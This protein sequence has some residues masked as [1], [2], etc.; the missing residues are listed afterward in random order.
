M[1]KNPIAKAYEAGTSIWS[2][3]LSRASI[4]AVDPKSL[5]YRV[6]NHSVVGVTTN[7][8]IFCNAIAGSSDYNSAM[9]LLPADW[10]EEAVVESLIVDDVRNACSMLQTTFLLTDGIDGKVS[11]EVDPRLAHDTDGTI[12]EARRLWKSIN[13]PNLLIKVPATDAGLVAI[14]TLI[15]EGIS[16]N[17]TLIFSLPRYKQVAEAFI[18][19]L[20]KRSA[21]G[22]SIEGITSVASFFIS[23]VDT[24][25]DKLLEEKGAKEYMG[26]VAVANARLA[27]E[28]YLE[29]KSSERWGKL[30]SKGGVLQRTLWASTGVKNKAYPADKYVMELVAPDTVNT[31][32]PSALD[33]CLKDGKCQGDTMSSDVIIKNA[34]AVMDEI[35]KAGVD[36]NAVATDLE[37][38]GAKG[39]EDAWNKL[40]QSVKASREEM[41]A[42]GPPTKKRKH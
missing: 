31:M 28:Y 37:I 6:A 35:K 1:P 15:S 14:K 34:H 36:I 23:R 18:S 26:R 4:D 30:A 8:S 39:F 13:K 5:S 12:V 21:S 32:P 25:V 19:G 40:L 33:Y 29:L 7:P 41:I 17:V 42:A 20:E 38:A 3:D 2:D 9:A 22:E 16:V 11:V 27:Y 10:T 24:A